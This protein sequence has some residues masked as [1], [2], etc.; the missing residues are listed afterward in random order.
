MVKQACYSLEMP[1][2]YFLIK[3]LTLSVVWS[4]IRSTVG[5][6]SIVSSRAC[7]IEICIHSC[8]VSCFS[9]AVCKSCFSS[10]V[11]GILAST[12]GFLSCQLWSVLIIRSNE[13]FI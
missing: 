7:D 8:L 11:N 4:V 6:R 2:R 10:A 12:S 1:L 13:T 5:Q 3:I 9:S